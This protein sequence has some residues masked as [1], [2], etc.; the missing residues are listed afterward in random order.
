MS[1]ALVK[2]P[3][4]LPL[5]GVVAVLIHRRRFTP[6]I[7]ALAAGALV[8]PVMLWLLPGSIP[9]LTVLSSQWQYCEDSLHSLLVEGVSGMAAE[10]HRAVDYDEIFVADRIA[11]TTVFAAICLWRYSRATDVAALVRE[12]GRLTLLLLLGYAVS[13]Y[14]WYA[15][16]VVPFAALTNSSALRRSI[17]ATSAALLM[18]YAVPFGW[19]ERAHAHALWSALRLCAAFLIPLLIWASSEIHASPARD[20]GLESSPIAI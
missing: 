19:V 4:A 17:L 6:L 8:V 14:P 9:A 7:Q 1:A 20:T 11:S 2:T 12:L 15:S 10:L 18:L 16:W 3:G 5:A 13:V